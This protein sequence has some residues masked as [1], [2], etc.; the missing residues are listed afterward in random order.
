M[1]RIRLD[2]IRLDRIGLDRIGLD[3]RH[4]DGLRLDRLRV[5]RLSVDRFRM[6]RFRLDR[7]G[8]DRL[9]L[10]GLGLDR[11]GLDLRRRSRV[12]DGLVGQQTEARQEGARRE[13][14]GRGMTEIEEASSE[15]A[16]R[17]TRLHMLLAGV[18]VLGVTSV[19]WAATAALQSPARPQL[20]LLAVV[21][22]AFA[23]A[24]AFHVNLRFGHDTWSF[25][26]SEVV[27][28]VGIILVPM[29]WLQLAALLGVTVAHVARRRAPIKVAFNALTCQV[30][31]GAA[32]IVWVSAGL[33]QDAA[34]RGDLPR[35]MLA[36][37][38]LGASFAFFAVTSAAVSAAVAWS[39]RL[40]FVRVHVSGLRASALIWLCNTI[41][42]CGLVW[43]ASV[44]PYALVLFPVILS[45]IFLGYRAYLQALRDRDTWD[46]LQAASRRLLVADPTELAEE[47]ITSALAM[48]RAEYA[49]L[50]LVEDEPGRR[51]VSWRRF[52]GEVTACVDGDPFELASGWWGR[53]VADRAPFTVSATTSS[54]PQH[55]DLEDLG[56][57]T[58]AVAPLLV[59]GRCLGALRIG[60]R[61]PVSLSGRERQVFETWANHVSG[62]ANTVNLFEQLRA[63]AHYDG[64]TGLPNRDELTRRLTA[65]LARGERCTVLFLDLD[66]FKVVNDSLGHHAGDIVLQTA[67]D[68]LAGAIPAGATAARFGGDEFVIVWPGA[69]TDAAA[70]D[71]ARRVSEAL[72]APVRLGDRDLVLTASIGVVIA[73]G[74][75]DDSDADVASRLLR[76]ADAAMYLAKER[77][78]DRTE[79]FTNDVRA[80][81]VARLEMENDLRTA[82]DRTELAVHFQPIIGLRDQRVIGAEALARWP[83][84][85]L[86]NVAPDEFIPVA[87][88]TGLILPLGKWVMAEALRYLPVWDSIGGLPLGV[89]INLSPRQLATPT[90]VGEV[91]Q[92]FTK[93]GTNPNRVTFEVT[94]SSLV[95]LGGEAVRRLADLR[96]LGCSIALDDFGTG[97]SSLS[98]LRVLPVDSVKLDRSFVAQ[99]ESDARDRAVVGGLLGLAHA[100][101]LH[102]VAEGVERE[103]QL[104][105]LID[106]G[107]DAAQGYLLRRPCPTDEL[108]SVV[109]DPWSCWPGGTYPT[110]VSH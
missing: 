103:D 19:V 4:V 95:D 43:T 27:L 3:G 20:W 45:V 60:F 97:Y 5:D 12:H 96:S 15:D 28:V 92:L 82:L 88:E 76:D 104:Q 36:L 71:A 47:A 21:S 30:G 26:W 91:E 101:D 51:M 78:R 63:I 9:G 33:A 64:L 40:S 48:L 80:H 39:Q 98:Y 109:A 44:Q 83:R 32:R 93:L 79:V 23:I 90:L 52:T 6:D 94:E 25:T 72:T 17:A 85:G 53:V 14:R 77:G 22:L 13:G 57:A 29:P 69:D 66:H 38:L 70:A 107:C 67:A 105:I 56:L 59:Q 24:D 50:A 41:L 11:F 37:G 102:V 89:S 42:G 2:R 31:F 100:L 62:A 73:G 84:V 108:L 8:L 106:L 49:E 68:R 65:L 75:E 1:D 16:G 34:H 35:P 74:D 58:V 110:K 86:P 7:L 46:R 18:G 81:A 87:E 99:L 61:G 10:D 54:G 55:D